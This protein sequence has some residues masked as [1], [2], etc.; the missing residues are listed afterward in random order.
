MDPVRYGAWS[1]DKLGWFLGL[2]GGAWVVI[3]VG[4]LPLLL[5]IG[6]HA[7][8][9]ALCWMLVWVVL[10]VLVAVPVRGRSAFRW[11]TDSV[12]RCI[13]VVMG[14]TDWQSK[15]PAGVVEKF[16]EADLPGVL[17][18]IRT[19]R[20]PGA[21][22]T[23]RRSWPTAGTDLPSSLASPTRYR[24]AEVAVR[25][26]MGN[27]LS[28]CWGARHR[29]DGLASGAQ[30]RTVPDDGPSGW[31]GSRSTCAATHRRWRWRS[32]PSWAR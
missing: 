28:G 23:G 20:P 31:R 32:T 25:T 4:G 11:V 3:L 18:G 17:S 1:K 2:S 29:G 16:D 9:L 13:G 12:F 21:A 26:R 30:I 6:S 22:V 27:G 8:L 19:R 7:W 15:A 14:W 10:I 5:A 24:V